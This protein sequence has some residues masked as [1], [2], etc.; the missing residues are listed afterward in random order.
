MTAWPSAI[1]RKTL[2]IVL[3]WSSLSSLL[4]SPSVRSIDQGVQSPFSRVTRSADWPVWAA[5]VDGVDGVE[6][7]W[8]KRRP[9]STGEVLDWEALGD[10]GSLAIA[11]GCSG[12]WFGPESYAVGRERFI[13]ALRVLFSSTSASA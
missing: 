9:A 3:L 4:S 5:W 11:I 10:N 12:H 8:H 1:L 6:I 2:L 13:Q 7:R